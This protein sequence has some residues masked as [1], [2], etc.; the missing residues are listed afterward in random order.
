MNNMSFFYLKIF[1]FFFFFFFFLA[2]K[3][4][5]HLD[6]RVFVMVPKDVAIIMNLLF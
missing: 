3:F 2:V 4:S 6:R 1:S 5:L